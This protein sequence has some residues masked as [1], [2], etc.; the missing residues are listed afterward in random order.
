[1]KFKFSLNTKNLDQIIK[2]SKEKYKVEVGVINGGDFIDDKGNITVAG[3]GLVNEFGS[4]TRGIPERSFIRVPLNL[5]LNENIRNYKDKYI[6]FLFKS[7]KID[8][9][10]SY[11][12]VNAKKII[13]EAFS[14]SN[15]GLWKP[16][17]KRTIKQKG[18]SKPLIDSGR[19]RK[20][21]SYRVVNND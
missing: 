13:V 8:K 11:L 4:A 9:A 7:Q 5:H 2:I 17:T 20:S 1:M 3:Y 14:T 19:L 21:I 10:Y 15:N 6:N 18:S 12:G 16:N